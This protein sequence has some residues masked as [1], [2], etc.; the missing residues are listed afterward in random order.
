MPGFKNLL[1]PVD[2]TFNTE[3]A[4]KKAIDL[5]DTEGSVVHLLHVL[6]SS[7]GT[8]NGYQEK[9]IKLRELKQ[10]IEVS[11]PGTSID[12]HVVRNSFVEKAIIKLA[13]DLKTE[14]IIIGR[15]SG[16]KLFSFWK[17]ISPSRIAKKTLCAVLSLKPGSENTKIKSIVVPFGTHIPKRKLDV[18]VPLTWKK[19]TT[20]YLVAMMNE[21]K[22]FELGD[23]SITHTLIETYRL[24]KE[25]VNCQVIHKLISGNNIARSMLRFAESVNA[26]VLVANP[27]EINI[28]SLAGLDISD[29][30][31]RDSKIQLLTVEPGTYYSN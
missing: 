11:M 12:I 25:D 23:S 16:K 19:K 28:S 6:R 26:D 10:T 31:E 22:D 18:L 24:L 5:A 21:L 4:V 30:L 2:F 7:P 13:V 1:V 3:L 14:I 29:I 17:T 15:R 8:A 27:D 9:I 20:V